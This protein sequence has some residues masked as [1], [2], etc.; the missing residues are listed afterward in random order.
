MARAV[1]TVLV[2]REGVGMC[3]SCFWKFKSKT[4]TISSWRPETDEEQFYAHPSGFTLP[5]G[6]K[7]LT[8]C[9]RVW[10]RC[11]IQTQ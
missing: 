4:P 1:L 7:F 11:A 3:G 8:V 6:K 10:K 2:I 5:P 9:K